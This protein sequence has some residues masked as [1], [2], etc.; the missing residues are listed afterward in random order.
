MIYKLSVIGSG[1]MGSGIAQVASTAGFEV[2]LH[3]ANQKA[4]AG[5]LENIRQSLS[6]FVKKGK[7]DDKTRNNIL[8]RITAK[9]DLPFISQRCRLH[10]R[11]R[12]RRSRFETKRI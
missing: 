6:R 1:I 9:D 11:G 10:N 4:L 5:A 7:I 3:D 8:S 12:I 2:S